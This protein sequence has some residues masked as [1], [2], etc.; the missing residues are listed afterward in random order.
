MARAEVVR[1]RRRWW[2]WERGGIGRGRWRG[3]RELARVARGSGSIMN[4]TRFQAYAVTCIS[5]I[6]HSKHCHEFPTPV[7]V[8]D[9]SRTVCD[10]KISLCDIN[11]FCYIFE[12]WVTDIPVRLGHIREVPFEPPFS[13]P[14]DPDSPESAGQRRCHHGIATMIVAPSLVPAAV[15]VPVHCW[16][17]AAAG[18]TGAARTLLRPALV[19]G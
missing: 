1:A 15:G 5:S 13:G 7:F 2:R 11:S 6:R 19:H 8:H 14:V 9:A 17:V 4:T 18:R 10:I 16:R 12:K 3:A